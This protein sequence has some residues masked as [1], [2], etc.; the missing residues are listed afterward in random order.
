MQFHPR[1]DTPENRLEDYYQPIAGFT[2]CEWTLDCVDCHTRGEAMGDGHVYNNKKETQYIQC[3]TCHGTGD[4]LPLTHTITDE[5]DLAL[6]M[7]FLNPVIDL[8]VGDTVLMTEKGE[9]LWN[10]RVR[11]ADGSGLPAYELYSKVAG[12]YFQ[13]NPVM[14]SACEGSL[15][16]QE[17]RYCHECHAIQR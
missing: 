7:A 1:E 5:N 2:H 9:L 3:R 17:S 15:D 16:Q 11:P 8:N 10:I 13:Y 14:G 6:R 4:A 12:A